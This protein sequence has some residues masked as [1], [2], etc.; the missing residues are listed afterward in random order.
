[1]TVIVI[2]AISVKEGGSLVVLTHLLGEMARLRPGW[3]WHIAT[4]V[5]AQKSLVDVPGTTCH[6]FPDKEFA[7]WKVR[8]WYE[9]ALPKLIRQVNADLFFSQTNYLPIRRLACPALLLVQHAGHFSDRFKTMTEAQLSGF[10]ARLSWRLKGHWVKSSVRRAQ[11]VT[12][13]T[14]ALAKAVAVQTAVDAKHIHVIP[15]GSGQAARAE[16]LP[17]A[18]KSGQPIR[19]GYI[20]KYGVQKNFVVLFQAVAQLKSAG[21]QP[22]LVLTLAPELAANQAVLTLAEMLGIQDCLE[23]HGNL[24]GPELTQLYRSLH[25]FVFPSWCESFGFPMVEALAQGLPLLIAATESN[26]EVTGSGGLTF[27]PDDALALAALVH[28]LVEEPGWH[29][30]CAQA[31]LERSHQFSWHKAA[32]GTLMLMDNMIKTLHESQH[33]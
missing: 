23:N 29:Q 9:V 16:S 20:T 33:E 25:V 31:S 1:M 22:I 19:I 6:V 13:Q 12:V 7:G 26:I 10:A 5:E 11:A 28:R 15:H 3:Q 32:T 18:P 4:N 27:S 17:P 2:N 8:L 21:L 14:E 30:R 24:A